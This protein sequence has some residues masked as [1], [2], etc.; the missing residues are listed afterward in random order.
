MEI[1]YPNKYFDKVKEKFPELSEI[2]IEKI[3]NYG[4]R[5]L[6]MMTH[7]NV[8]IKC[9]QGRFFAYFGQIL[10][11]EK[12]YISYRRD[13]LTAKYRMLYSR[14]KKPYSGKYYFMLSE[15]MHNK[16]PKKKKG[17]EFP[18]PMVVAYKIREEAELHD[19]TYLYELDWPEEGKYIIKVDTSKITHYKCIAKRDGFKSFKPVSTDDKEVTVKKS[20]KKG[21][22]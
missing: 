9:Q 19:G 10:K 12:A 11:D 20:Q 7:Y 8:D 22:K 1:V 6:Y 4:L 5:A 14:A 2:Q 16:M 17:G 18:L 13:K 3:I 21:D 15:D